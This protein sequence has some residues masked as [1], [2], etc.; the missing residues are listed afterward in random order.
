MCWGNFKLIPSNV[1][2]YLVHSQVLKY[3]GIF[4]ILCKFTRHHIS[5]WC[6]WF[7]SKFKCKIFP[8]F[9]WIEKHRIFFCT[10][11]IKV[12]IILFYF[13]FE[14]WHVL[15]TL[16]GFLPLA[17]YHYYINENYCMF[18]LYET[19]RK[20]WKITYTWYIHRDK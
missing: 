16:W 17:F 13:L 12:H 8:E 4:K 14:R 15:N 5:L 6:H 2:Q 18:I 20:T 19:K 9:N 11:I 3:Y 7:Y 1:R 10:R